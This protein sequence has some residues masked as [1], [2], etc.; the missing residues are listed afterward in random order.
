MHDQQQDWVSDY[1]TPRTDNRPI[2]LLALTNHALD[3]MLRAV[4]D[5]RATD[6]LIRIGSQSKDEIIADLT[7]QKIRMNKPDHLFGKA[8]GSAFAQVKNVGKVRR[9]FGASNGRPSTIC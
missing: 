1:V 8:I 7:L 4:V 9:A 3:H 2:M 5:S 6:K